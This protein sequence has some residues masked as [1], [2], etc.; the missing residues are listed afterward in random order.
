MD[1][2]AQGWSRQD[3]RQK[4]L[5][6]ALRIAFDFQTWRSLVRGD[7]LGEREA[8]DLMVGFVEHA[9]SLE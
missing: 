1:V 2:A 5:I 9:A 3:G 6:A 8:I 4:R 7:G